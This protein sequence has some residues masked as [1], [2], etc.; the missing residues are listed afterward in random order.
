MKEGIVALTFEKV[1]QIPGLN[2]L[3]GFVPFLWNAYN[4]G[5]IFK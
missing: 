4:E 5:E 1:F 3:W 2:P